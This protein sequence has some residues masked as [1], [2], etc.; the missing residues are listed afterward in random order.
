MWPNGP[1]DGWPPEESTVDEVV[2]ELEIPEG[3]TEEEVIRLA[4]EVATRADAIYR[5][6]GGRGLKL[7]D[8]EIFSEQPATVPTGG[9][10]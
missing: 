4:T 3:A 7:E 2:L 8:L 1:P 9:A 10:S 6:G 5:E